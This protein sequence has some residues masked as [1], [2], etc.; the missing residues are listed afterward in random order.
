MKKLF[1]LVLLFS[2]SLS[3]VFAQKDDSYF[4]KKFIIQPEIHLNYPFF[5]NLTFNN[6]AYGSK[7][8]K[9]V[10]KKDPFNFGYRL[11]VGHVV[12]RNLAILLEIGQ[13][14]SS[15]YPINNQSLYYAIDN[16]G[17][18]DYYENINH[19]MVDVTTTVI[20]PKVELATKFALLPMG[21][22]HQIGLGLTLSNAQEKNYTYEYM[23]Y[24]AFM[25]EY[26]YEARKYNT[27]S[28][29]L[30]PI[31]FSGIK[32]VKK[33]M[34]MY[35]LS[36]RTPLTKSLMF[37]YGL[38]YTLSLGPNNEFYSSL[39]EGNEAYTKSVEKS[40]S[41]SRTFSFINFNLGLTFVF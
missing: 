15:V 3:H 1:I 26:T 9:L 17:Y 13:D 29:D 30:D 22:S 32:T 14:Y 34:F 36:M 16:N 20:M 11:N 10:E 31:N 27:S 37:N 4:G 25:N 5:N 23:Y 33:L 24:D 7:N 35:A 12:K 18:Y 21:L 8:D 6:V 38:K 39:D 40:I 19:E 2:I 41:K 28:T